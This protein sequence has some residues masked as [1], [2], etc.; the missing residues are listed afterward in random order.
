[1][2]VSVL[3]SRHAHAS[4]MA[5]EALVHFM[6]QSSSIP[7][8]YRKHWEQEICQAESC[9]LQDRAAMDV[10]GVRQVMPPTDATN[11]QETMNEP[12]ELWVELGLTIEEKQ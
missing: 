9:R 5:K 8:E 6:G 1:M 10:L 12:V 4:I 7:D 2:S 3:C 11:S